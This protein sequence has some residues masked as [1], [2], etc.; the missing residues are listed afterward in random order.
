MVKR[1]AETS[2][3]EWLAQ[4]VRRP[5]PTTPITYGVSEVQAS[6]QDASFV[7]SSTDAKPAQSVVAELAVGPVPVDINQPQRPVTPGGAP[8]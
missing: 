7:H 1:K 3:D 6:N 4:G 2:L 5:E 8:F